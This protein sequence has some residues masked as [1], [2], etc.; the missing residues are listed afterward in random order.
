MN[1]IITITPCL[2]GF[3]V[4][5]TESYNQRS[6]GIF[7]NFSDVLQFLLKNWKLDFSLELR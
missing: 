6:I 2:L 5:I 7:T 1:R 4:K 3:D